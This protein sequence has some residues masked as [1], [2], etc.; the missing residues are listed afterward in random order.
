MSVTLFL[1]LKVK[2]VKKRPPLIPPNPD[3]YPRKRHRVGQTS[4]SVVKTQPSDGWLL[5][6]ERLLGPRRDGGRGGA[7]WGETGCDL[8]E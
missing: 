7:G 5:Y 2:V 8:G 6:N 1:L 4:R 3:T